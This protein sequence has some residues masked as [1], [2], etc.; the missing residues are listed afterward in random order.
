M[1]EIKIEDSIG[2]VLA[3][4]VTEIVR[5]VTKGV[6]FRK[7]YIIKSE[8]IPALLK[9]GKENIFVLE[10]DETKLHENDAADILKNICQGENLT[11]SE[12][13]E[14]KIELSAT[15]IVGDAHAGDWHRQIS[16][17]GQNEIDEFKRRGANVETGAFDENIIA[18]GF[19]F[20][21]LAVGT[22][23]KCNEVFFKNYA[24]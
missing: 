1:K 11:V 10:N 24:N 7:G 6:N 3:H 15:G 22:R 5:G 18:E 14:G 23:L 20:K 9:L 4:D 17:L 21:N 12:V 13:K 19:T 16:F 8:D 2:Q